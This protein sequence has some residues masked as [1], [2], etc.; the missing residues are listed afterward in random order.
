MCGIAGILD[1]VSPPTQHEIRCMNDTLQ[2]RGPDDE[3]IY[4]KGPAGLGHRR[5][6]ILDLSEHGHQPMVDES[7]RLV[8]VFNGE[9]YNYQDLKEALLVQGARFYSNTDTEVVLK[10]YQYWGVAS[11]AKLEG[12][13]A[14]AIWDTDKEEMCLVRDRFGVKP[15]YYAVGERQLLFGSEL[16]ALLATRRLSINL[17]VQALHEYLYYGAALGERTFYDDIHTLLPGH[18]LTF[19]ATSASLT[20]FADLSVYQ[21]VTDNYQGATTQVAALLDDAVRKNLV[22]DVPV[23][24]M[25]SGGIDSSAIAAI[26]AKYYNGKLQTFSADFDFSAKS[27]LPRARELARAIGSDHHEFTIKSVNLEDTFIELVRC[28]DQPFGD[29]ANLPIYLICKAIKPHVK[30]ILQGDAGDELFGGYHRYARMR[31]AALIRRFW[32]VLSPVWRILFTSGKLQRAMRTFDAFS[33]PDPAASYGRLMCQEQLDSEPCR[34]F[35]EGVQEQLKSYDPLLQYRTQYDTATVDEV[36]R[37]MLTD[38]NII[39][40]NVYFEKVDRPSMAQGIEVRVPFA[41]N[42]LASYAASLPA[43]FKVKGLEK[44]RILRAALRGTVPDSILDA[45]KQGFEV[46]FKQWLRGPMSGFVKAVLLDSENLQSGWFERGQLEKLLA[47]N[48][49]GTRDHGFLLNKLLNLCLWRSMYM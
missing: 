4:I 38:L 28:H 46:P 35:S 25:L 29:N 45:P 2:H 6:S 13:F 37:A 43:N 31:Y 49:S 17:N 47:E 10:A 15:V 22:A 24:V 40:P 12:M 8:I 42:A 34:V 32:P 33:D 19:S 18:C 39:L 1:F 44:K 27:E 14:F 26:A 16:K 11:F 48:Q 30:V 9:I 21:T 7:G 41:D 36:Q 20:R 23:G 5:L 3:G